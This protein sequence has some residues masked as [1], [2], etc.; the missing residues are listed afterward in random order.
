[1]GEGRIQ[2]KEVIIVEGRDDTAAINSAVDALTI[3]THGFGI[4]EKTWKELQK[5]YDTK[6]LIVFT[7]PDFSGREIRRR[8]LEKFPN[9][10]EA[11]LTKKDATKSG[12]IGIENAKP[13]DIIKAIE[14]THYQKETG[15]Q[16]FTEE[17][18][19]RYG[20][21]GE[22]SSKELRE[23]VGKHLGI[24]YSNGKTFLNKINRY[25]ITRKELEDAIRNND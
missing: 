4:S 19:T 22:D 1:M 5:A 3:E 10:K 25:G 6:G 8:I 20:L 11:F 24:G 12:D 9:A 17:D 23:K 18:L 15:H 21:I 13:Q 7:D 2:V 14:K 16:N